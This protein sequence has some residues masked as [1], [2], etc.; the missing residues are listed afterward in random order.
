MKFD[1]TKE[2]STF[3]SLSTGL[4]HFVFGVFAE[5]EQKLEVLIEEIKKLREEN[6]KLQKDLENKECEENCKS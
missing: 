1:V 4:A 3:S 6:S 2:E 5:Y